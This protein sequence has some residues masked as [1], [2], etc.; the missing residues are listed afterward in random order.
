EIVRSLRPRPSERLFGQRRGELLLDVDDEEKRRSRLEARDHVQSIDQ[1]GDARNERNIA[2]RLGPSA[3]VRIVP[4][5]ISV[6]TPSPRPIVNGRTTS[7][8]NGASQLRSFSP[9]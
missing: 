7:V 6:Q 4:R 2:V 3:W 1:N 8:S 9:R 5:A